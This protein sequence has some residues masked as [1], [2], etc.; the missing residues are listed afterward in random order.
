MVSIMQRGLPG[1]ARLWFGIIAII[2][3]Y[4]AIISNIT[5]SPCFASYKLSINLFT[6]NTNLLSLIKIKGNSR[7]TVIDAVAEVASCGD[8]MSVMVVLAVSVT[9][10]R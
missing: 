6:T 1:A 5:S 9:S 10:A 4:P 3:K 2:I 8:M 7:S